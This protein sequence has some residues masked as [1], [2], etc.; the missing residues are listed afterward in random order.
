MAQ[1][2]QANSDGVET[3]PELAEEKAAGKGGKTFLI[4][5]VTVVLAA[6]GTGG[7]MAYVF[8]PEARAAATSVGL[9]SAPGTEAEE[10]APVEYGEFLEFQGL[11]IN[12][13]DSD[14]RRY[15]MV[16]I[17][18]EAKDAKVLEVVGSK[19]VVIRDR[20]LRLLG[21]RTVSELAS[22]S[23]RDTLKEELLIAVND[24][25]GE[26]EVAR[27]YFTQYVLQ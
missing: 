27:L 12:P 15:L 25:L 8:Y 1:R 9:V 24:I 10:D 3:T 18:L 26:E 11:I 23:L 5:V 19:E 13:A 17:G 2:D 4:I 21:Q 20:I 16:N 6:L 22:V 14:G 7:L